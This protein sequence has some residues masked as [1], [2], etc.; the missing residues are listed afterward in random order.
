[1]IRSAVRPGAVIVRDPLLSMLRE[2][3]LVLEILYGWV[4]LRGSRYGES[5]VRMAEVRRGFYLR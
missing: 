1:M 2:E 3:C 4:C 5:W